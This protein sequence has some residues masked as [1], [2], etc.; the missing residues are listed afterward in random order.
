MYE[1][2]K[3][4]FMPVEQ[5]KLCSLVPKAPLIINYYEKGWAGGDA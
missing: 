4:L 5:T 3:V 1:K 2:S